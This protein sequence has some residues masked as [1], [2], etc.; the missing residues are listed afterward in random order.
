MINELLPILK[1]R[2][3]ILRRPKIEDIEDRLACGNT[4]EIIRMFGGDTRNI[5]KL[6]KEEANN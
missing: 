5:T 2:K 6:T 4:G 3:T 1:G